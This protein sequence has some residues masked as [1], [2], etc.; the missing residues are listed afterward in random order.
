[1]NRTRKIAERISPILL[2]RRG[3]S[4]GALRSKLCGHWIRITRIC[5]TSFLRIGYQRIKTLRA[6]MPKSAKSPRRAQNF[7]MPGGKP[8]GRVGR[9]RNVLVASGGEAAARRAFD[10]LRAGGND[11]TPSGYKG[12]LVQLPGDA[13]RVGLRTSSSGLAVDLKVK[14]IPYR[15]SIIWKMERP[16]EHGSRERDDR[17]SRRRLRGACPSRL[18]GP[19]DD[20]RNG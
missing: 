15:V 10:Y 16:D 5:L 4:S 9:G 7:V 11:V 6:S 17:R 18:R 2:R 3:K 12:T 19:L 13:G 14:G 1:M 20:C 8:I